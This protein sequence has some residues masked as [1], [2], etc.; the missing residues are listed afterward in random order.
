[1]H[2][3]FVFFGWFALAGMGVFGQIMNRMGELLKADLAKA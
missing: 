3:G 1:L 2:Y